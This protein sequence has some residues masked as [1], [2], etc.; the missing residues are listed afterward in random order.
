MEY[1]QA[2]QLTGE[3]IEA[4]LKETNTA[5]ICSLSPDGT[6]H[7]GGSDGIAGRWR[8]GQP[9]GTEPDAQ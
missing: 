7:A 9:Q 5:R 3:E 2:P 8:Q 4:L 1:T 6:I